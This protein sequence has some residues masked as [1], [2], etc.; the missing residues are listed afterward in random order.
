MERVKMPARP[1][2]LKRLE[3]SGCNFAHMY[4]KPYMCEVGESP[5]AYQFTPAEVTAIR[6]ATMAL[7]YV[8]LDVVD[9]AV[10]HEWA[11]DFL[12]ISPEYRGYIRKSWRKEVD[13]YQR[14]DLCLDTRDGQYKLFEYNGDTPTGV[15]E[16]N[17]NF[18][19][20]Q[21]MVESG[22]L[23]QHSNV[24][25]DFRH[26][27]TQRF[28]K[29]CLGNKVLYFSAAKENVE[30]EDTVRFLMQCADDAGLQTSFIHL[31][32]IGA[33]ENGDFAD[34]ENY[35]IQAAFLLFPWEDM[36]IGPF[37]NHIL[38]NKTCQFFEP[39]WKMCWS[40]KAFLALAWKLFP[41]H[42]NLL[43]AYLEND[44]DTKISDLSNVIR[45]PQ[46]GR[47]GQNMQVVKNGVVVAQN[48]GYYGEDKVVVQ[49]HIEMPCYD[50]FYPIIGSWVING[51]PAGVLI[52]EDSNPITGNL[53]TNVPTF[54][55]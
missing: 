32:D 17:A 47:E 11:M 36:V 7:H 44:P 43:P 39:A 12:G 22:Q 5:A 53:S 54:V 49:E 3:Q 25:N 2:A 29:L 37:Q 34:L 51:K 9:H 48:D 15:V 41:D 19:W 38:R 10:R 20:W 55:L 4:G 46:W 33:A 35:L 13:L 42:P 24:F 50:G 52:R 6:K 21:D 28:S 31:E 8:A 16:M 45:K 26:H 14:M 18:I 30:E 27:I 40:N 23:P 1:D